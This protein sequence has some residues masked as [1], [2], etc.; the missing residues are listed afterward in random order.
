MEGVLTTVCKVHMHTLEEALRISYTSR[1]RV[2]KIYMIALGRGE[3]YTP[4]TAYIHKCDHEY[5]LKFSVIY[6]TYVPLIHSP[7]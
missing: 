2:A 3:L 5:T 6:S 4:P 7:R 1:T